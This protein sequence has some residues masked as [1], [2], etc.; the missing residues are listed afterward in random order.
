MTNAIF[1]RYGVYFASALLAAAVP[2]L[3]GCAAIRGQDASGIE[4]LLAAAGF[5]MRRADSPELVRN[6]ESM[7]PFK[8]VA[9][10]RGGDVVYTY[11]DPVSCRCLYVS[12]PKEFVEYQRL[13][14]ERQ[15]EEGQ[16][17]A[18]SDGMDWGL[19][20]GGWWLR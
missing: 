19:W 7:P 15:V 12:R 11:A 20:G 13:A 9:R 6:L 3:T 4:E 2:A 14:T 17:W 8:L 10:G 18:E 16:L 5:Q 1:A